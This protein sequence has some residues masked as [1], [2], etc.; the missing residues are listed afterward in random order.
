MSYDPRS[1]SRPSR[2]FSRGLVACALLALA[3]GC[4]ATRASIGV[5][6]GLLVEL[7]HQ[8]MAGVRQARVD[9]D[10][11]RDELAGAGLEKQRARDRIALARREREVIRAQIKVA[12]LRAE[13]AR[14]RGTRHELT[15]AEELQR[16][17][18]ARLQCIE[19]EIELGKLEERHGEMALQLA[20]ARVELREAQVVLEKARALANLESAS[21]GAG[22][23]Q[24]A[25]A[26][27]Q[28]KYDEVQG[29]Q[30]K[31]QVVAAEVREA[32]DGLETLRAST[33]RMR[34]APERRE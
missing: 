33:E 24:E 32:R 2:P 28:A 3:A 4:G 19:R 16:W 12:R 22:D 9:R 6:D 13:I 25:E 31:L 17:H 29:L 11:A 20:A 23:L 1:Q 26:T 15:D 34:V 7:T 5:D 18:A 14:E 30:A 27:V 8:Q 21:V 10:A